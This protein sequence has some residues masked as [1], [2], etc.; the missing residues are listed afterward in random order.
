MVISSRDD[1]DEERVMH[2]KSDNLKIMNCHEAD[3]VKKKRFDSLK[4]RYQNNVQSMRG[5]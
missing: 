3:E 4:N 2:S 5:S 1:D